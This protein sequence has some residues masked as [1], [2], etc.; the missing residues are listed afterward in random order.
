MVGD[1]ATLNLQLLHTIQAVVPEGAMRNLAAQIGVRSQQILEASKVSQSREAATRELRPLTRVPA[2]PW[3]VG[4]NIA[5]IRM[6]NIP[7]FTGTSVDTMDV[8]RW[9]SRIFSLAQAHTL[10]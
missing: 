4:H 3:G 5:N 1:L 9:M 2:A 10:P 7:T 8:V 6:H